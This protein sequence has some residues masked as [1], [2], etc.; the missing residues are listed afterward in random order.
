M[1]R[2]DY[3]GAFRERDVGRAVAAAGWVQNKRD[4]GG[5]IFID[6]KD[7]EGTLQVVFDQQYLPAE[8]FSAAEHLRSQSVIRVTGSLRPRSADTYNPRLQTGTIELAAGHLEILSQADPLP[9]E[10]EDNIQV[11]EDLRLRYRYLDLRRPSLCRNLRT[12]HKLV[13]VVED[14]LMKR[15]F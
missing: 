12:R 6:L 2:T 4:M 1:M 5:V 7:R 10:L 8:D 15:A 9:F 13:R 11:R 14:F 3:C